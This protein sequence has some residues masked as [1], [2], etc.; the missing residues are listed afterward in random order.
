MPVPVAAMS[1][2]F[3]FYI[4]VNTLE[5]KIIR[6]GLISLMT[7]AMLYPNITH[8]IGYKVPTVFNKAEVQILDKLKKISDPKDYT[9]TWWDY[10]YPIWFYSN[11][12]TLIDGGKH[13]HDNFIISQ[14][15]NTDSPTQAANLSRLAVETYVSSDYKI[16]ADTIFKNKQPDQVNPNTMLEELRLDDYQL[17]KKTRD[18]YLYLPNRMLSIFPTV[19]LFSNIDLMSGQ[20][21]AKPFF[22][23][24]SRF[25]DRGNDIVLGNGISILKNK[26][27]VKIGNQTII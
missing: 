18:I 6:Y 3:L 23:Q 27:Q 15:L 26:G 20:K 2:V 16:V 24:S 8:I 21:R 12:N 7:I 4:V 17:P 22:F 14:I 11:T 9:L 5:S 10:G 13:N 19:T 1:A 25:K